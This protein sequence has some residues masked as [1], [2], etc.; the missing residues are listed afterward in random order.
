MLPT[1]LAHQLQSTV[2]DYLQTTFNLCDPELERRLFDFLRGPEGLLKGPYLD[3]RLPFRKAAEDED[4]PLEIRPAFT[5]PYT[6]Q[7]VSFR[8]LSSAND[9]N[10]KHSLVTT[11]TGSGKTECFLYPILDHCWRNRHQRGIK[12][13]LLYPMNALANDQARRL[14]QTLNEDPRLKGQVSAGLY[15]GGKGTHGASGADHLIDKRDVLRTSSLRGSPPPRDAA[16]EI[17]SPKGGKD[18]VP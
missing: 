4:I 10:P 9:R 13:I 18:R 12:A 11:G 8:R 7:L 14:A 17:V 16:G 6:H 3:V 5:P 1:V 2:V 15:V